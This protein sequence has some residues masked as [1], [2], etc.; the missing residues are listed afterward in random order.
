[1]KFKLRFSFGGKVFA[2]RTVCD[3]T[4]KDC[5]VLSYVLSHMKICAASEFAYVCWSTRSR[6]ASMC[7][8]VADSQ[9]GPLVWRMRRRPLV[10]GRWRGSRTGRKQAGWS[11][12]VCLWTRQLYLSAVSTRGGR[13]EVCEA[14]HLE[15]SQDR[16]C[17]GCPLPCRG[18][19]PRPCQPS[20][21]EERVVGREGGRQGGLGRWWGGWEGRPESGKARS[22]AL[23]GRGGWSLWDFLGRARGRRLGVLGSIPY[24]TVVWLLKCFYY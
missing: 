10:T 16:P 15:M 11:R 9:E 19:H 20:W 18:C 14:R 6:G 3:L 17:Q 24:R 12:D 7:P 13:D 5:N 8:W 23:G 4:D 21:L 1:M 22:A 2:S